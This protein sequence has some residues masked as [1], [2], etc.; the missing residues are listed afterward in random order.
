MRRYEMSSYMSEHRGGEWVWIKD[1]EA[2][3][4]QLREAL[5]HDA[6]LMRAYQLKIDRLREALQ[7][8]LAYGVELDDPRISYL[9]VQI[10]RETIE[11]AHRAL[12]VDHE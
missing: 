9:A 7:D 11:A 3:I 12:E 1:H 4:A 10:G 2:E 8:M 6:T 5:E